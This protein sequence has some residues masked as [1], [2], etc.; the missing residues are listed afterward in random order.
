VSENPTRKKGHV[1]AAIG[2]TVVLVLCLA[3][4][5]GPTTSG[6]QGITC[7]ADGDCNPGLK[8]LPYQIFGDGGACASTGRE[9]LTP[10]RADADCK[11]Q[12]V[13][14]VCFTACGGMAVCE[15]PATLG[16]T[17][18]GGAEGGPDAASEA[19]ADAPSEAAGD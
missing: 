17:A 4:G 18:D 2:S 13:G 12:S 10:C 7:T 11:G 14:L 6:I 5:C 1:A 3:S 19:A 16:S 15:D 8:C 9:C